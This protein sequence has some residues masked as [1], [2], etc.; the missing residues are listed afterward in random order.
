M[1]PSKD[2][3]VF[4]TQKSI[5]TSFILNS[6]LA[7]QRNNNESGF[8]DATPGPDMGLCLTSAQH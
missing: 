7:Y 1:A 8:I 3:G 4:S 2:I 5:Q 6:N